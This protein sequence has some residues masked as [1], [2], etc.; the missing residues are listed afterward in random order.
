MELTFEF[1]QDFDFVFDL[2]LE[3]DKFERL[4]GR[5]LSF[6]CI[7]TIGIKLHGATLQF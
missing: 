2:V 4:F 3:A 7:R 6:E 1:V 5:E